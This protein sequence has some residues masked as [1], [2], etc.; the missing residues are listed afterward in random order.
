[1]KERIL[2]I[3]RGEV[4]IETAEVVCY[5]AQIEQTVSS[6]YSQ[7]LEVYLQSKNGVPVKSFVYSTDHRVVPS[8][9]Q[10]VG[11]KCSIHY[12]V[13]SVGMKAGS[14]IDGAFQFVAQ[15]QEFEIPYRF[16]VEEKSEDGIYPVY[17][18]MHDFAALAA[19][20]PGK[21]LKLFLSKNFLRM[22]FMEDERRLALYEQLVYH[23]AGGA[24][25]MEEFLVYF[26]AKEPVRI[27]MKDDSFVYELAE[28][29]ESGAAE[30][31]DRNGIYGELIFTA[32]CGG[33]VN[34]ALRSDVPFVRLEK[35]RVA[36]EDFF[37]GQCR[38]RFEILKDRLFP[39]DN[40]G[41]IW[42]STQEETLEYGVMIS[43]QC[44]RTE[45]RQRELLR[46]KELVQGIQRYIEM[47]LNEQEAEIYKRT[48]LE[49]I[50]RMRD[51]ELQAGKEALYGQLLHG[52]FY[53]LNGEME[54]FRLI[55]DAT[56]EAVSECRKS[57]VVLYCFYL[58]LRYLMKPG[59]EQ[60]TTVSRLLKKYYVEQ[61][62]ALPILLMLL[63]VD[64]QLSGNDILAYEMLREQYAQGSTSPL[65]YIAACRIL[66]KHPEKL[67]KLEGFELRSV[68]FA[69][70][71]Q[72]VSE[73]LA[74][75]I[76]Q[77]ALYEKSF[78][79]CVYELLRRLYMQK[80]RKSVLTGL[81]C[82]LI[83]GRKASPLYFEWYEKGIR[84]DVRLTGVYEYYLDSMPRT[85]AGA[86]PA[87]LLFF[88]VD[89]ED[90]SVPQR[91][92]LYQNVITYFSPDSKIY[93]EYREQ[94]ESFAIEQLMQGRYNKTMLELYKIFLFPEMIDERIAQVLPAMLYV[95]EITCASD[96][97]EWVIVRYP[98]LIQEYRVRM[99]NH[100]ACIPV[101]S[102][103]AL[104][105]F[106]DRNEVRY[107]NLPYEI[108]PLMENDEYL[109]ICR[110]QG[111]RD[112]ILSVLD[113]KALADGALKRPEDVYRA[114]VLLDM[115]EV[116]KYCKKQ[117]ISKLLAYCEGTD[118]LDAM[119][120]FLLQTDV[121]ELSVSDRIKLIEL[122]AKRGFIRETYQILSV[123]G[124]GGIDIEVLCSVARYVVLQVAYAYD[125]FL[126]NICLELYRR[127]KYNS[128]IIS[129]LLRYFNGITEEMVE[130]LRVSRDDSIQV[131]MAD[132]PERLLGQ[133]MFTGRRDRLSEVFH[134]YLEEQDAHQLYLPLIQAYFVIC[135]HDY[136]LSGTQPDEE[137]FQYLEQRLL[138]DY[139]YEAADIC[140]LAL[141]Q[142]Y[143][144][145]AVLEKNRCQLAKALLTELYGKGYLFAFFAK[146][147]KHVALPETLNGKVIVEYRSKE[148]DYARMEWRVVPSEEPPKQLPMTM[149]YQGVFAEAV[150]LFDKEILEYTVTEEKNNA[151]LKVS[152]TMRQEPAKRY[153]IKRSRFAQINTAAGSREIDVE[154]EAL[155][156][157]LAYA[158]A[159][160]EKLFPLK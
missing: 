160:A 122:L 131:Q 26:G 28:P 91:E 34:L 21:A 61:K 113:T 141:L 137:V 88:C 106:E 51:E 140:K 56:Y 139:T 98:E 73:G 153:I 121:R 158:D 115:A 110:K 117:V 19:E 64:E 89:K 38:I 65:L 150:T 149:V 102:E 130:L 35:S 119:D 29:Q 39:G 66:N 10:A 155:L 1:M 101:Y 71:H 154:L 124:Y 32:S 143:G 86:M 20:D 72:A 82:V 14:V 157:E 31:E 76:A 134:L 9:T 60:K 87:E 120:S 80:P 48:L 36:A 96:S 126:L 53:F 6:E 77:L 135:C 99:R 146:L 92:R 15:G 67:K 25:A 75:Q 104:I 107:A 62:S 24:R 27:S 70:K 127:N 17:E 151:V 133:M 85:Y 69:A 30:P 114:L 100:S 83:S 37:G 94:M 97:A 138:E 118:G 148:A 142:V 43:N 12:E 111:T 90:L 54:S 2:Q 105:V 129:Y 84:E 33:Y 22:P 123:Y 3:A 58:Y 116:H 68:I 13:M 78:R 41:K 125:P 156:K 18:T 23:G 8:E 81:L 74:E 50:A 4:E 40:E 44:R 112:M 109:S 152:E 57:D 52:Y 159:M 136:F 79:I 93:T 55:M 16:T 108:R 47:K 42:I 7:K 63:D 128:V 49:Q 11:T 95:K 147:S 45:G 132:F 144:D 5:P 59:S 145:R 46:K 103:R